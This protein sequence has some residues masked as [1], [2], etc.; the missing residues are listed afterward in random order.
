MFFVIVGVILIVMNLLGVGFAANWTWTLGGDLWKFAAPFVLA[1][2]WW[3]YADMSGLN[4]RREMDKMDAKRQARRD[5]NMA[6]LG[7][8]DKKKRRR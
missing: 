4:K 6:A 7:T 1:T 5:D 3:A 2:L 8:G